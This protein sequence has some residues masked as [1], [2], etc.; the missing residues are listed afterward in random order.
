MLSVR[1]PLATIADSQQQQ[2]QLSPMKGL[3]LAD[4][5]NTVSA[6]GPGRAA[7]AC[8]AWACPSPRV[9]LQ[10]PALSGARVLA[11]KTARR[12]FQDPGEPVSSGLGAQGAERA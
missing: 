7:G 6:R 1:V 3:S 2:L 10:P 9:S 11:S 5:E 8:G 12:I 4:K